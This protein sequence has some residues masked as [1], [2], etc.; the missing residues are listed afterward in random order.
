MPS[1]TMRTAL[2][3]AEAILAANLYDGA[4]TLARGL[5]RTMAYNVRAELRDELRSAGVPAGTNT[6][7]RDVVYTMA[8]GAAP[9]W[10]VCDGD[11]RGCCGVRHRSLSAA[12]DHLRRDQSGCRAQGGYSDR[13]VKLVLDDGTMLDLDDDATA[14]V[15]HQVCA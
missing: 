8:Y 14:E 5:H 9:V 12:A 1:P 3:S 13:R 7:V 2:G 6:A 4:I 11:V 15:R 10:Y